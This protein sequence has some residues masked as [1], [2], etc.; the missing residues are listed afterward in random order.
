MIDL[1]FLGRG[2]AFNTK[3]GNTS[4]YFIKDNTLFLIDCG[5][6]IFTKI[7]EK[8][9]INDNVNEVIILIT[10][11]HSDHIGSLPSLIMYCYYCKNIKCKIYYPN[12]V[13]ITKLLNSQGCIGLYD[14][15]ETS[16]ILNKYNINILAEKITHVKEIT[17]YYYKIADEDNIIMYTGDTCENE[18]FCEFDTT[19]LYDKIYHD[20][21]LADYEG[22]VHTSLKRLCNLFKDKDFR[23]RIYC[24]HFDCNEAIIKAKELGF[25]VVEIE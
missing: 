11:F 2:S 18:N 10:H 15:I 19:I 7:K 9:L 21:C 25:N 23:K 20:C 8:D 3:E 1:K 4:A 13:S 6:T 16:D 12:L 22:N 24:M 17:S 5:E 14:Y